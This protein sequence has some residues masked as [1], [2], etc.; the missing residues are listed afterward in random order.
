MH[1]YSGQRRTAQQPDKNIGKKGQV[2]L[3]KGKSELLTYV[4]SAHFARSLAPDV[5]MGPGGIYSPS[6]GKG[7]M[8]CFSARLQKYICQRLDKIRSLGY[9]LNT[10]IFNARTIYKMKY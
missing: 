7:E 9:T 10:L 4:N 6:K 8:L 1:E 3:P 2:L 5:A